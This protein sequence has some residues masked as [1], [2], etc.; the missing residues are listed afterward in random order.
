MALSMPIVDAVFVKTTEVPFKTMDDFD[1][2]GDTTDVGGPGSASE[3]DSSSGVSSSGGRRGPHRQCRFGTTA[4]ETIPATPVATDA[5]PSFGSPPG[6]S[7]AALRQARDA[8]RKVVESSSGSS[9]TEEQTKASASIPAR[10]CR[11]GN[12]ALDTVPATPPTVARLK[13]LAKAEFGSTRSPPG[14]SRASMRQERDAVSAMSSWG[15]AADAQPV[16]TAAAA[17]PSTPTALR[18]AK[19]RDAREALLLR[20]KEGAALLKSEAV[21]RTL[22]PKPQHIVSSDSEDTE[23]CTSSQEVSSSESSLPDGWH[24]RF[25]STSLETVPSTPAGAAGGC[26]S[27]PGLSRAAMRNARDACSKK[28]AGST[29]AWASCLATGKPRGPPPSYSPKVN[30]EKDVA[31]LATARAEHMSHTVPTAAPR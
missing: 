2:D 15:A 21:S 1:D 10:Q 25:G 5:R 26:R 14:L 28:Q 16:S 6:L 27:P 23:A 7:R 8:V 9:G 13:A 4:L 3:T 29:A 20:A 17:A 12:S 24:C 18:S 19:R 11:F 30:A 31:L 22:T